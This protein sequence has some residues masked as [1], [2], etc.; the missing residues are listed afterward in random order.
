MY[1]KS[2]ELKH[3][4][5][6]QYETTIICPYICVVT[7]HT[8]YISNTRNTI[9]INIVSTSSFSFLVSDKP[10]LVS[11]LL[12]RASRVLPDESKLVGC[13][14]RS[15]RQESKLVG[16][17]NTHDKTIQKHKYIF[18]ITSVKNNS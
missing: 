7:H 17:R 2:H 12:R 13:E 11:S 5:F 3:N 16:G 6:N 9:Q 1:F 15:V 14:K 18:E 4:T 8:S 10:A